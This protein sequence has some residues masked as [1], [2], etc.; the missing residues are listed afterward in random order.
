VPTNVIANLIAMKL[1]ST[2]LC[3]FL[4]LV[5]AC[6]AAFAQG[7]AIKR[8]QRSMEDLN[9][10]EAIQQYTQILEKSDDPTAK[11][12]LAEAYRKTNDAINAEYWYGQVVRLPE[13]KSVHKLY[14]G[15]ALQRNGKCDQ[16]KEWFA[17]FIQEQPDDLRGQYLSRA[18]DYEQELLT[19]AISTYEVQH[20]DFNSAL[21]DFGATPYQNGL[22]FASDRSQGVAVKRDHAWTGNPFLELF[23]VET[24]QTDEDDPL[25]TVYGRP[26][27]FSKSFNSKYHDAAVTFT[28][29]SKT[30]FFTRNN[31]KDGK[32]GKS[33]DGIIKLKVFYA[34][35]NGEEGWG[36]L[37]SLPFNSDEY[38]VLHP[39]LSK[40]GERLYFASDMPGGFGG[41]DVYYSEKDNGRWGPPI[42]LGPVVNTEGHEAF[43]YS[44]ADGRIYFASDGHIGLGGYDIFYTTEKGPADFAQ[45]ENLG[46]PMNSIADDHSIMVKED[47]NFGYFSSNRTGG[48]GLDDI[49]SFTRSGV[50]VEVLVIDA[51]TR[52]P[53]EGATVLNACTAGTT[54]TDVNGIA[55][56]DMGED[57]KCDFT[58]S[59]ERY[60]DATKSAS[61]FNFTDTKLIVEIPLKP[62]KDYSV[63]GFVY[64][65]STG[66]PLEGA[67]VTLTSS[68][69]EEEEELLTDAAGHYE[70][71]LE[72]GCCYTVR[73][74][75]E[76]YLSDK[77]ENICAI[78]TAETR[79]FIHNLFLQPTVFGASNTDMVDN[80][81]SGTTRPD[82]DPNA[83]I[84]QDPATGIWIDSETGRPANGSILGRTYQNG[85]LIDS[86]GKFVK[87]IS[88]VA[89]GDAI[90]YLLHIYYDFNK[91]TI[92]KEARPELES[93]YAMMTDNPQVIIE[94]ASHTDA[95]GTDDYNLRLSQRRAE[96]V[97]R[98]L[99]QR[100]IERDRMV[101]RGYG[102][103]LP[104]NACNNG[105][106][107]SER[108]HQFNR[109]TEFRVL[110]CTDCDSKG[111]KSLPKQDVQ[112][113]PCKSCPF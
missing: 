77:Q 22:L 37:Q 42:N 12:M 48:A 31:F 47:G 61:T 38:S 10:T 52:L 58:A 62:L 83:R 49:Y 85:Q 43:P 93:L 105:V 50:P 2:R 94:I 26:D 27:K 101:P 72:T 100:G 17:L 18:C 112:V 29:D 109:R 20:L 25:S 7:S 28:E 44:A 63:E 56:A 4:A 35:K 98:Y 6:S 106:P 80:P 102:E 23:Y 21:D 3:L 24:R 68:C 70:F 103:T 15:Q 36:E 91:A 33:D 74:V 46:A 53:I 79:N 81:G 78:D 30:M 39:A 73:G 86:D 82:Q 41:M 32:T 111:K 34:D 76:T 108:E 8:A 64:D 90:P 9:Y 71:E 107:C 65:E 89:Q 5:F 88:P 13:S 69:S 54:V 113:S 92:R 55:L 99:V 16:A 14:Y 19:K 84:Y 67:R 51:D 11:I 110:G 59:A 57:E 75:L 40:S 104:V 1:I 95:R 97:V 87:G 45:P 60:E 66:E 96:S